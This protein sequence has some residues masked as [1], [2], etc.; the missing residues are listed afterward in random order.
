[1]ARFDDIR[2]FKVAKDRFVLLIPLVR[3]RLVAENSDLSVDEAL[4]LTVQEQGRIIF[5]A[6][7]GIDGKQLLERILSLSEN[8]S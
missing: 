2:R 3:A 1:M 4:A 5:A 7:Y 8:Q 6:F